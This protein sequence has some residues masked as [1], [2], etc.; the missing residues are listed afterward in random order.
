M[1]VLV[2][3]VALLLHASRVMSEHHT[4]EANDHT[5]DS[6]RLDDSTLTSV[7][8]ESSLAVADV[9]ADSVQVHVR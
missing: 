7:H 2:L 5:V 4:S 8:N 3:I 9:T 6:S 1:A